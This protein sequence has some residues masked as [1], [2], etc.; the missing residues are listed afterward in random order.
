MWCKLFNCLA[1]G[2]YWLCN[3]Y[4]DSYVVFVTK[5]IVIF[6]MLVVRLLVTEL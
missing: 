6:S 5:S 3:D 1:I 4:L 2:L